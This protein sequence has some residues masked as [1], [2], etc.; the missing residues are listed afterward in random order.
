MQIGILL[1]LTAIATILFY[2]VVERRHKILL[3]KMLAVCGFAVA[4]VLVT[5]F[6][7]INARERAE[8]AVRVATDSVISAQNSLDLRALTVQYLA[9]SMRLTVRVNPRYDASLAPYSSRLD[10][11]TTVVFLLCNVATDTIDEAQ[12]HAWTWRRGHSNRE[13]LFG[14]DPRTSD[15]VLAPRNCATAAFEGHFAVFDSV[16]ASAMPVWRTPWSR[17]R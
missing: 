8:T 9:D 11:T 7:R 17:Y 4:I 2:R 15:K 10:T 13:S 5:R 1:V 6:W 14:A 12:I 16:E 3:G